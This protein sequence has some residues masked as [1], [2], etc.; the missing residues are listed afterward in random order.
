MD[1][2]CYNCGTELHPDDI[3]CP[4]CGVRIVEDSNAEEEISI[5]SCDWR[6]ECRALG[7][8]EAGI[9]YGLIITDFP[10]LASEIAD[11]SEEYLIDTLRQ[12]IKERRRAG[13]AAYWL[14]DVSRILKEKTADSIVRL[15]AEIHGTFPFSY[16]FIIGGRG[17]IP[18]IIYDDITETDRDI[19]SDLC[20]RLLSAASPWK[21]ISGS[22]ACISAGRLP[23]WNGESRAEF[24]SYFM[25]VSSL[26]PETASRDAFGL[27]A[28][29]WEDTSRFVFSSFSER[30]IFLSPD[31]G[32]KLHVPMSGDRLL[33]F[34]LHGAVQASSKHWY[35]QDGNSYPIAFSPSS[36]S[37]LSGTYAVGV[38]ACYGARYS[39]YAKDESA[40]LTAI[41]GGCLSFLGSSRIA[42]GSAEGRGTCADIIVG[43][44]LRRFSAG[45]SA[46]NA[47]AEA[48]ATLLRDAPGELE[49]KTLME[50]SLYG[51]PSLAFTVSGRVQKSMERSHIRMPDVRGLVLDRLRNADSIIS[52]KLRKLID[53]KYVYMKGIEPRLYRRGA[54]GENLAL[55]QKDTGLLSAVV[56]V[57]TDRDG[58]ILREYVSR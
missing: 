51:D 31:G 16:L 42:Y 7:R 28:A 20:Y 26:R 8:K 33:Y 15:L 57:V 3:F 24:C 53:D 52:A 17:V 40:L 27:S 39:G 58:G 12:Y 36:F 34:N 48:S 30:D 29:E 13:S 10:A 32:D 47:F 22:S 11:S 2:F 6:N 43:E 18:S 55:Y 54:T 23:T 50:F 49:M 5:F 14:L 37:L 25:A 4:S 41:T 9:P 38:E 56:A 45:S 44:F 21:G 46:G 19:D 35:G 1:R